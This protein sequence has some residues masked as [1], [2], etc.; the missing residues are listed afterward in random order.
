A[1]GCRGLGVACAAAPPPS[2]LAM[3]AP[4]PWQRSSGPAPGVWGWE[5]ADKTLEHYAAPHGPGTSW[6]PQFMTAGGPDPAE[7][8][9]KQ[10]QQLETLQE[11]VRVLQQCLVQVSASVSPHASPTYPAT[12]MTAAVSSVM[13]AGLPS[14]PGP[15][16]PALNLQPPPSQDTGPPAPGSS[17][18]PPYVSAPATGG[19]PHVLGQLRPPIAPVPH[20]A[21][22]PG[23]A[24][25]ASAASGLQVLPFGTT[26]AG[27]APEVAAPATLH[28]VSQQH[29]A[30][31]PPETKTETP[32]ASSVHSA[33]PHATSA[34]GYAAEEATLAAAAELAMPSRG[35]LE[36]AV[37]LERAGA[38]DLGHHQ[39]STTE[40][41]ALAEEHHAPGSEPSSPRVSKSNGQ[42]E[43]SLLQT[44]V[45]T[46]NVQ[47][48]LE[49]RH[50]PSSL[51]GSD[52]KGPP[53]TPPP[54]T[55]PPK[56]R[57]ALRSIPPSPERADSAFQQACVRGTLAVEDLALKVEQRT[58]AMLNQA[59]Q[60][61][62]GGVKDGLTMKQERTP[63]GKLTGAP[64]LSPE[65][66]CSPARSLADALESAILIT[67]PMSVSSSGGTAMYSADSATVGSDT[68]S[69]HGKDPG[70]YVPR[71]LRQLD[72]KHGWGAPG[73]A[74]PAGDLKPARMDESSL[75]VSLDIPRVVY[76]QMSD[77]DSD[78]DDEVTRICQKY[79]PGKLIR[80]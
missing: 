15:F 32:H 56:A 52:A 5:S 79:L 20:W 68:I 6:G 69:R 1:E 37:G 73:D 35:A 24:A 10:Q 38:A 22:L 41:G 29:A 66:R 54:Q 60:I 45:K 70:G 76:T 14:I 33:V 55:T 11:Q 7:I 51:S 16:N 34:G 18:P 36:G 65:P 2:V 28:R 17:Q 67:P 58:V 62:E 9:M 49:P 59:A 40:T 72:G 50:E 30:Q 31:T 77:D 26:P 61:A 71:A 19:M 75:D 21:P 78:S 43:A 3:G 42:A 44:P 13:T 57:S 47:S 48:G 46:G 12:R 80:K 53:S 39:P 4:P 74:K 25:A 8:I 23:L 64:R 27:G 63:E